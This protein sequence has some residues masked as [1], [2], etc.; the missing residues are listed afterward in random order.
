MLL[1]GNNS[2]TFFSIR[3]FF[4]DLNVFEL[5]VLQKGS[6]SDKWIYIYIYI[7]KWIY[8]FKYHCRD[9]KNKFIC[10][11]TLFTL[12]Y[13]SLSHFNCYTSQRPTWSK[14]VNNKLEKKETNNWKMRKKNICIWL[15]PWSQGAE[16]EAL[17][18]HCGFVC[19]RVWY[20]NN[21]Y[22]MK[23][24]VAKSG[25]GRIDP[26]RLRPHQAGKHDLPLKHKLNI[27]TSGIKIYFYIKPC[28]L[29][30]RTYVCIVYFSFQSRIKICNWN[31]ILIWT[32]N[33]MVFYM[34]YFSYIWV[35]NRKTFF[36]TIGN[37]TSYFLI[38][39]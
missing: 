33:L 5:Y 4:D 21:L 11:F 22:N 27:V 3:Y 31:F 26:T 6:L 15:E 16:L 13:N 20:L 9:L 29:T 24:I 17:P 2:I 34:A 25:M 37:G 1:H 35:V 12:H 14:E 23:K 36:I 39:W 7:C 19:A 32:P 30:W 18:V 28:E 10:L 38:L 8:V